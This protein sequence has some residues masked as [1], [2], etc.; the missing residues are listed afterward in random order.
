M[1]ASSGAPASIFP[2]VDPRADPVGGDDEPRPREHPLDR[3][4]RSAGPRQADVDLLGFTDAHVD[5]PR[6]L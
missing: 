2:E 4:G 1:Y 5:E 3:P 6:V